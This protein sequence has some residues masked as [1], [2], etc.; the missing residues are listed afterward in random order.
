MKKNHVLRHSCS[1][2]LKKT[3]MIMKLT[4]FLLLLT[5][6]NVSAEGFSQGTT[7]SFR[8]EKESL[9]EV[10]D[11]IKEES[12]Y[13]FV[14]NEQAIEDIEVS[15]LVVTNGTIETTMEKCLEDTSLDYYIEN[16]VVVIR[17][18]NETQIEIQETEKLRRIQ[19]KVSSVSGETIPGVTVA[20]KG[21]TQGTI[22]DINGDYSLADISENVVLV[23]SF[24]GM[25]TQEVEVEMQSIV[26]V[27]LAESS[28]G[29]NEV[30]AIGY[31]TVK[32]SDL[33]GSV[34]GIKANQLD[35]QSNSNLGTAIQGKIAGVSVE[36]AG[37]AP[38]SGMNL[39][40]RGAGSLNNNNPLILV[41]DIAVAS[42]DN[43]NPNDI[44]SIQVLKDASAAA[45]YGSRAA[46]GVVLISTKN[47]KK[48]PLKIDFN[49]DYGIQSIGKKQDLC[50]TDEWIK[51]ITEASRA[52]GINV[53]EIALNPEESGSGIDWQDKV[54]R[55]AS[56]QNYSIGMSG[57]S[58]NSNYNI[59]LGYL[60]QD[61][62]MDKT[63][64]TRFNLRIKS[65]FKK[66]RV[67]IGE[68]ILLT[69]ETTHDMLDVS[70]TSRNVAGSAVMMIPAFSIYDEDAI[71][72][73]GGA[74]GAVNNIF[75]PVAAL[76]LS[77][78]KTDY[79]KA[80]INLYAEVEITDGLKYKLSTGVTLNEKKNSSTTEAYEVGTFFSNTENYAYK[81]SALTK[82]WQVDNTL[83]Y[84]KTFRGKHSVNAVVGYTVFKNKYDEFDASKR[85]M[86][87]GIWSMN[88]GSNDPTAGGM[89]SENTMISYLGRVIYSYDN[90]YIFTG[91]F[92]RDGSSRLSNSNRWGNFPSLSAAWNMANESFF[93][94]WDVPISEL[95]I[96]TSYGKLGNQEIGDYQYTG[97]ITSGVN[98]ANG[99][100]ET[101]WT[102]NI[103]TEYVPSN[104]KWET[105]TTTNAGIDLAL[106]NGK[107]NYTLDLY[108]KTT[109]DLL[110]QVPLPLS[111]GADDDP[112]QN[113]GKISNKG[114][115]M[116]INYNGHYKDFK[117]SITGTLSHVKNQVEGLATGSQ[118]L[119][120][121]SGTLNGS[122]VTYTKVG[123][124][125]YS[126][127]LIKTDGLFR[128][129]EEVQNYTKNGVMIQPN[130]QAGDIRFVDANGDGEI[131]SDGDR[132]YC[133]SSLPKYEYGIRLDGAWKFID[134][135]VYFQGTHGNKIYNGIRTYTE[136]AVYTVQYSKD[137]LNSYSFN[138]DSDIPRLDLNDPNGNGNDNTDRFL[139][140]GSY[141]RLKSVQIGLTFPKKWINRL[142]IQKCRLYIGANNLVTWTKYKGY[143]PDIGNSSI[144][145]RGIDYVQYPLNRS[146]HIGFQMNF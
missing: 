92:R 84:N 41:D 97:T 17:K 136:S 111:A 51:V 14:F 23:F 58:D 95:K 72:G 38:G 50:T 124:P 55:L 6:I 133:G 26:N 96:R 64:Y 142:T 46:N 116:M 54:Y 143:N 7:M 21:T 88:A 117:Y 47:G 99:K 56:V 65:D 135:S 22:T 49:V 141:L 29:L 79:Y 57:G 146:Y 76:N 10:F 25:E 131:T 123:Y 48:G 61:G 82:Y 32:K 112:Y 67:K 24:V 128:S 134:A 121:S 78:S 132:V 16:N 119:T 52:A 139:E 115:E 62:I 94:K 63:D 118:V 85:G 83:S 100:S 120:G 34:G 77:N 13:S 113:A 59:S 31:G 109:T 53:P 1:N 74:S 36:S 126:F 73:Y 108:K 91:T 27:V 8:F 98:Y 122:A 35:Q 20:V 101:L 144:S 86:A 19:G 129:D 103:Q 87:D 33:T 137:L 110:L 30:I 69:Q 39:Q 80:L 105:T 18:K 138:K 70:G 44:E 9:K 75:N 28:I 45:I 3:L 93:E 11:K 60:D 68:S 71:G 37:G 2:A 127:F 66:G 42:M 81:S 130:A 125:I 104:L 114:L 90:R 12:S 40:I 43:L 140:N 89:S 102:G 145:S 107:L 5:F 4:S 15:Q 106:W